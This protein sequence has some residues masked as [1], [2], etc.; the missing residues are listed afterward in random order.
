MW[1]FDA[2]RIFLSVLNACRIDML[3][4]DR[5]F[6]HMLYGLLPPRDGILWAQKLGSFRHALPTARKS[7]FRIFA[8]WLIQLPIF[9]ILAKGK[10]T[11]KITRKILTI[12]LVTCVSPSF[13]LRG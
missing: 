13:Y 6:T 3:H 12:D 4:R 11:C 10:V 8:F 1:C 9:P 7:L 2:C 5:F